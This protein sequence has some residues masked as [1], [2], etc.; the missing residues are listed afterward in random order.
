MPRAKKTIEKKDSENIVQEYATQETSNTE[1]ENINKKDVSL[2]K[3]TM[4]IEDELA[5]YKKEYE[6]LKRR[7]ELQEL[8]QSVANLSNNME[9]MGR[10]RYIK[11]ISLTYGVLNLSTQ[12]YG[13]GK[14]FSIKRFGQSTTILDTD[15]RDIIDANYTMAENMRFYICDRQLVEDKGLGEV[16]SKALPLETIKEIIKTGNIDEYYE[17]Y[18]NAMPKQKKLILDLVIEKG[19]NG[20]ITPV[21]I[22]K[23]SQ[24]MNITD[25]NQRIEESRYY[26]NYNISEEEKDDK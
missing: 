2:N 25:L 3:Q 11:V 24:L 22:A 23:L 17:L 16:Y 9:N 7:Q 13:R 4:S 26:T 14:I 6:E 5:F 8:K 10:G 21:M 18:Q 20:E 12:P 1:N 19:V 15:L